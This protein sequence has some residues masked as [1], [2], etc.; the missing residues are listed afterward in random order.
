M[1]R[2]SLNNAFSIT[3]PSITC[4]LYTSAVF[5]Q[6]ANQAHLD[7]PDSRD[8][9]QL[10][11]RF[12]NGVLGSLEMGT[13]YRL[14]QWGI[15]IHGENGVIEVNFFT[16]SVTFNYLDGKDVYKRQTGVVPYK[17]QRKMV[18]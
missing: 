9:L 11:L 8:V 14:H 3:S 1:K 12:E 5:A 2:P 16:S 13:A 15:Q 10:L 6:A 17:S 4:L 7:T 18:D